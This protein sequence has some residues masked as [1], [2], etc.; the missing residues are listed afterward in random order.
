MKVREFIKELQTA[1]KADKSI[2]DFPVYMFSDAEGNGVHGLHDI[3]LYSEGPGEPIEAL[4][5][6]PN[7]ENV[8]GDD[9]M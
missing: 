4:L 9:F 6:V 7:D 3:A 5:L 2:G 1:V 8:L